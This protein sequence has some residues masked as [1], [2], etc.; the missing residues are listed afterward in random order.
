MENHSLIKHYFMFTLAHSFKSQLEK[1]GFI[2]GVLTNSFCYTLVDQSMQNFQLINRCKIPRNRIHDLQQILIFNLEQLFSL[3]QATKHY[4]SSGS[5]T[6]F[7]RERKNMMHITCNICSILY[8]MIFPVLSLSVVDCIE[9]IHANSIV[10]SVILSIYHDSIFIRPWTLEVMYKKKT[11]HCISSIKVPI[12]EY[13]FSFFQDV[14]PHSP[15]T[16]SERSFSRECNKNTMPARDIY[17]ILFEM[18]LSAHVRDVADCIEFI[19]I[20]SYVTLTDF[21][22]IIPVTVS[23]EAFVGSTIYL[24]NDL[25][26]QHNIMFCHLC[27]ANHSLNCLFL[28]AFKIGV[29]YDKRH[30]DLRFSQNIA[31]FIS[32]YYHVVNPGRSDFI[33]IAW[34]KNHCMPNFSKVNIVRYVQRC[35]YICYDKLMFSLSTVNAKRMPNFNVGNIVRYV[36]KGKCNIFV[37]NY[38]IKVI[39][40]GTQSNI[41]ESV[42]FRVILLHY[43]ENVAITYEILVRYMICLRIYLEHQHYMLVWLWHHVNHSLNCLDLFVSN[44]DVCYLERY[45]ELRNFQ[46]IA[47]FI[48]HYYHATNPGRS[49]FLFSIMPNFI[50]ENIVQ[51]LLRCKC[52]CYAKLKCSLFKSKVKC[53]PNFSVGIIVRYDILRYFVV[54]STILSKYHDPVIVSHW[55]HVVLHSKT[56]VYGIS[57]IIVSILK[58]TFCIDQDAYSNFLST[59]NEIGFFSERNEITLIIYTICNI[60]CEHFFFDRACSVVDCIDFKTVSFVTN[61]ILRIIIPAIVNNGQPTIFES[62]WYPVNLQH[63]YNNVSRTFEILIRSMICL[64]INFD[65]QHK[66]IFCHSFHANHPLNCLYLFALKFCVGFD[67]NYPQLSYSQSIISLM[68]Q[69]YNATN[70]DSSDFML[71][72]LSK[73]HYM[74]N[75]IVVNCSAKIICPFFNSND[76]LGSYVSQ[77]NISLG[78]LY[79]QNI[80]LFQQPI[81]LVYAN[82]EKKMYL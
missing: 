33:L 49:Y 15:S 68:R 61:V 13:L 8:K 80:S 23:Y 66:M 18:L 65:Y 31:G 42:C 50:M 53:M 67:E 10:I 9:F 39:A 59:G 44:I 58:F 19:N 47:S 74:P 71:I 26:H 37:K 41:V 4:L 27:H 17:S 21:S 63:Y 46:I 38:E 48:S 35:E 54:T 75:F 78:H 40:T 25:E 7:S 51:W 11:V 3:H 1:V 62:V 14:I 56:N 64:R 5:E 28:F 30:R 24:C 12:L 36:Q 16:G 72:S 55:T 57:P 82:N 79:L 52:I 43:H 76:I 32:H 45:C 77:S 2:K 22:D 6:S 70:I 81:V 73:N 69:Y 60:L 34:S 29:W 20:F